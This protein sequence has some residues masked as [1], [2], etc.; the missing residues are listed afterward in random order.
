[1]NAAEETP[2]NLPLSGEGQ[3]CTTPLDSSPDKGRP[4]GVS[5]SDE[6]WMRHALTLA[7]NAW[8]Q[9]EVPVGAVLIRDGE[10]LAEGWNQPITLHD[11]S[12]H[13][14]MLAMRAAGQT[15]GNY[16]LPGTTLYITLEPCLMC[17]GAMLHARV[18]RVVFGAYDPKTGAAGSAFNLLQDPRHYHKV[19][20]VQGGVL[21][22]ECA[23]LLQAFFRER[24]AAA[25]AK[26]AAE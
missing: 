10:I 8:Q 6:H 3:E 15:V 26:P 22:E 4:G 2:P 17:V 13:A 18:E 21:Q 14:E 5:L 23:A 24:R 12:A 9:G 1:M 19:L 20:A 11:P 7:R 16:R 25:S